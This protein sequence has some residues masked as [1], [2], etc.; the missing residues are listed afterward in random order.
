MPLVQVT[1]G[2]KPGWRYGS[3]GKVYTYKAGDKAA[4]MAAKKK[5]IKQALAIQHESGKQAEF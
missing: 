3:K 1:V 2:G 4:S 5:A